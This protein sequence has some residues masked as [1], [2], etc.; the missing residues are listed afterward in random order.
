MMQERIKAM[1]EKFKSHVEK[2][3]LSKL[4]DLKDIVPGLTDEEAILALELCNE[5]DLEAQEQLRTQPAFLEVV[6]ETVAAR[7]R[8]KRRSV[9]KKTPV[10]LN[11]D[12]TPVEQAKKKYTQKYKAK[13]GMREQ[14]RNALEMAMAAG[15]G[16]SQD[17]VPDGVSLGSSSSSGPST[18]A[19]SA[20]A[21]TASASKKSQTPQK[22]T[23]KAG[24]SPSSRK[25]NSTPK[26]ASASKAATPSSSASKKRKE[27][28]GKSKAKSPT[29]KKAR[30][31]V[32]KRFVDLQPNLKGARVPKGYLCDGHG[33]LGKIGLRNFDKDC[34]E[35]IIYAW[36]PP[37]ED[38]EDDDEPFFRFRMEDG[39]EEDL[40]LREAKAAIKRAEKRKSKKKSAP[41][42]LATDSPLAIVAK[43][44]GAM[45]VKKKIQYRGS[46]MNN[47]LGTD[48]GKK[49]LEMGWSEARVKAFLN[50]KN[51]PNAYYY[52]FNDLG[53]AQSTGNWS[54]E[55][56]DRFI[57]LIKDGVDY[58]WGILSMNVPGRVGYQCSNYYRLLIEKGAITDPNY[59]LIETV[60]AKTGKPEKKLKFTRPKNHKTTRPSNISGEYSDVAPKPRAPRPKKPKAPRA[61]RAPR[62]KKPRKKKERPRPKV[63]ANGRPELLPGF[64]DPMTQDRVYDPAISPFG[65]VMSYDS[66]MRTLLNF[67]LDDDEDLERGVVKTKNTCP[68]TKQT[69]NRRQLIKL[70]P[71]N[72]EEYRDKI[73][74]WSVEQGAA[75]KAAE[76][77]NDAEA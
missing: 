58:R 11:E 41:V 24:A 71:Q 60:N 8:P 75:A 65:H 66:W 38:D 17:E 48:D 49:L 34:Y 37:D 50:R 52:R 16:L 57:E 6:K 44:E 43:A 45:Q 13:A 10:K 12:G 14:M 61:P 18:S 55:E 46:N 4:Q 2:Q 42:E 62:E 22:A 74:N 28:P 70:T 51:N 19:A 40:T 27:T 30:S 72:F 53:E 63:K 35:G 31:A 1:Q 7:H 67:Q 47:C 32:P 64:R 76:G 69:L 77:E 26:A 23:K 56:H 33:L 5:N 59:Q 68:F 54:K 29:P 21:P 9:R 15:V 39:D 3:E 73:V 25:K 20:P 36:Q